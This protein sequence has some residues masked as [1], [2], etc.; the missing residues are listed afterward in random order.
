MVSKSLRL[1]TGSP[2]LFTHLQKYLT[3]LKVEKNCSPSTL[4]SYRI[5]LEKL[6]FH[7][8]TTVSNLSD[9]EVSTIRDYIYQVT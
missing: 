9:V 5:E 7:L 4:Y 1:S 8:D 6:L 3:Y 2:K